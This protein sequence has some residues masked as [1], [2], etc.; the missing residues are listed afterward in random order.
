MAWANAGEVKIALIH[1]TYLPVMGG[2]EI[3]MAEH[4]RLFTEHGHEVTVMCDHGA[5]D[6]R[7]I[8]LELFP[9]AAD[10]GELARALEPRL[11]NMD[12]V[13]IHNVATM[14]FHINLTEA[15]WNIAK[16]LTSVR[17]LAWIHDLV[18]CNPDYELP[19][20][21]EWPWSSLTRAHDRYR[22]IAV[23]ELRKRQFVEL[24]GGKCT[25]I[26]NGVDPGRLLGLTESITELANAYD[27]PGREIVLLHPTRLLK[28]KN[29]E[30]GL[31]VTAALKAAGRSCAY[32]ITGAP[33]AQNPASQAYAD[34]LVSLRDELGL[35]D[36]A[37]FLQADVPIPDR[38]LSS[39]FVL[40]DALFFPSKQEGFGLPVLEAALH[41]LPVFCSAIE[42]LSTL[43]P[44]GVT[45]FPLDAEPTQI[46]LTIAARLGTTE[47]W[48]ARHHIRR[49][50]AWPA[51]YAN[52]L[53]PLLAEFETVIPA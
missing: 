51:V 8:K 31:R 40:A 15:L 33:D 23:S 38:D 53:A 5:S 6:D 1:Y 14:P 39:L 2:V 44:Q 41:R 29:V 24:T 19:A 26:P 27:L 10:A 7:R 35:Q 46:A 25:V 36:D 11:A 48:Q 49:R 32:L 13:M 22:Y 50:Y 9:D 17:F 21:Q 30:L 16:R 4:A 20:I 42:P 45:L 28:R 3:I 47:A 18:A 12:I 52:Y 43:L 37:L 34:Y